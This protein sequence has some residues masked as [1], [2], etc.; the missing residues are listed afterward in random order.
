MAEQPEFDQEQELIELK[1]RAMRRL[2]VAIILVLLA[3][4]ILTILGRRQSNSP[5]ATEK[6][7]TPPSEV[8][9]P[10]ISPIAPAQQ[11]APTVESTAPPVAQVPLPPE[12]RRD[13]QA[14]LQERAST[15]QMISA[16]AKPALAEPAQVTSAAPQSDLPTASKVL[17]KS[18]PPKGYVVQLGVFSNP[19]NALAL[20]KKLTQQGVRSYTETRLHVGPFKDKEEADQALE[21]IRALGI[22]AVVVPQH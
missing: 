21:K 9:Q 5:S 2:I 1:K 19:T 16:P 13:P 3:V 14:Q 10:P 6:P 11:P 12:V 22:H 15:G 8:V 18:V 4:A 17:E 20:Q 7:L